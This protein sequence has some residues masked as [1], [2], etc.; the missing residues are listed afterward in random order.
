[1]FRG[2]GNIRAFD[3][4]PDGSLTNDRVF[5]EMRAD[6]SGIPDGLKVDVEGNVYC[7]GSGGIWV[8]DPSGKHL[9][10]NV[11]GAPGTTNMA[12]GGDDW[13]TL[14]YTTRHTL[15]SIQM[16]ILRAPVPARR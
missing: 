6:R 13:R 16:K 8:M 14:F 2:V 15:G 7:G 9:G 11:H 1:M 5:C 3:V 12:W 10:T 4:S